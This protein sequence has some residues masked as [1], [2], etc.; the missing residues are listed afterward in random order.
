[1][2]LNR[3]IMGITAQQYN[4]KDVEV[5]TIEFDS[6]KVTPG[7]LYVALVGERYDGHNFIED[8]EQNGAAAVVTQRKT[9]TG[10]P[11]IVVGQPCGAR[12]SGEKFLR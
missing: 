1:M 5:S 4:M 8:V 2:R 3:L 9:S 12:Y 11:Q 10:L 6:R 7:A